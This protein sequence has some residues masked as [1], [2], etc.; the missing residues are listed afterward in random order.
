MDKMKRLVGLLITIGLF[1][2]CGGNNTSSVETTKATQVMDE[3]AF[4]SDTGA[5]TK[6]TKITAGETG[7]VMNISEGT[8]FQDIDGNPITKAPTTEVVTEKD[9]KEAKATLN[10]EVDGKKVIPTESVVISVPAPAG[11]KDGD[12]VQIEVPDDGSITEKS[13]I[14]QK[15]IFLIVQNGKINIRVFPNAF[16]KAIVIVVMVIDESTN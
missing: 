16:K 8:V 9:E 3:N 7:V 5:V 12:R 13:N 1:F 6:D 11:S 10:F 2:G 15:L 14:S 4:N